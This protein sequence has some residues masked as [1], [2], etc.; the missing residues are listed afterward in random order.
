MNPRIQRALEA[1]PPATEVPVEVMRRWEAWAE[2]HERLLVGRYLVLHELGR[3]GMGV[4]Y[5]GWDPVIDRRVAIKTLELARVDEPE[6]EETKERFRRETKMVAG[7][8]HPSIVRVFDAGQTV[9][10]G[11]ELQF[12]VMEYLEGVS[13]AAL[14]A[15]RSTVPDTKAVAI[16]ADI[17]EA[18]QAAHDIQIIHRDIK[19]S[20]IFLSTAAERA[21]L[22][23]FG[24]AKGLK[25]AL[26]QHD[27]ILGTPN[28]LAPERLREKETPVD[29]RSD[30]F[31]LGVLLF[32]MLSGKAPF[33]GDNPYEVIERILQD[34]HP[35]LAAATPSGRALSEVLDRLLA[36]RPEDRYASAGLAAEELRRVERFLR[37]AE[38]SRAEQALGAGAPITIPG[39]IEVVPI[40]DEDTGPLAS[41]PE[42]H[43]EADLGRQITDP[44]LPAN[45]EGHD[46]PT[47]KATLAAV[48]TQRS[49][50]VSDHTHV[51]LQGAAT[52][53]GHVP[54][55][56]AEAHDDETVVE[57]DYFGLG[58]EIEERGEM[59]PGAGIEPHTTDVDTKA[60]T[61]AEGDEPQ[62]TETSSLRGASASKAPIGRPKSP[63]ARTKS[64]RAQN[65]R[66]EPT[67]R[68]SRSLTRARSSHGGPALP[69]MRLTSNVVTPT[70]SAAVARHTFDALPRLGGRGGDSINPFD[71]WGGWFEGAKGRR[72][73]V[74]ATAAVLGSVALGL[75]LGR[76]Q[77]ETPAPT[78]P[79]APARMHKGPKI[80]ARTGVRAVPG[81]D[82]PQ[83]VRLRSA[84][85]LLADAQAARTSGA[86]KK[87]EQLFGRA[88]RASGSKKRVRARALLGLGDVIR[89]RGDQAAAIHRYRQVLADHPRSQAAK[90]ARVALAELG[91]QEPSALVG[92]KVKPQLQ[93]KR[94]EPTLSP[95]Q[96]CRKILRA[97][98]ESPKRA[99]HA[100]RLLEREHPKA[101]CIHWNL[102]TKYEQ[103]GNKEAALDAFRR[104]LV[105]SPTAPRREAALLRIQAL[106]GVRRK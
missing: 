61:P 79:P 29:G 65:A 93:A 81:T 18:L 56:V 49:A 15:E 82:E 10:Y 3:G 39:A 99:I 7:L 57:D 66:T 89:L 53:P 6:R 95:K 104:Y 26:T 60:Q 25:A 67:L 13:L 50:R 44:A 106:T 24:I 58:S 87:A 103:L 62:P 41:G 23:D 48:V 92:D 19:P 102:G 88:L 4:V 55:L 86:L 17:A 100:L 91:F 33:A 83:L 36:K 94:K 74:I 98:L 2:G 78:A 68:L 37:S 46:Q 28:Y 47:A 30:L 72:R 59:P 1:L 69:T 21:V 31:S 97:H 16:A 51:G 80:E 5:E 38:D 42:L 105:L 9:S 14:L 84:P 43:D 96:A 71:R 70:G 22:L 54:E 35:R 75:L 45:E 85:E 12:Y 90:H 77:T 11:A 34:S 52:Q 40:E 32:I 63:S 64:T 8:S 27:Q 73:T 101:P 76:M 20:N